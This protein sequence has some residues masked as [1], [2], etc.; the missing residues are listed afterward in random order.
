MS[1][2][3]SLQAPDHA[4]AE[5]FSQQRELYGEH[6]CGNGH[7]PAD[8]RRGDDPNRQFAVQFRG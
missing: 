3:D 4:L 8:E 1:G 2:V 7:R 5:P 6:L